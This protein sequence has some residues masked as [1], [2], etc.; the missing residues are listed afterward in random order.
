MQLRNFG[1][2]VELH[3]RN[4]YEPRTESEVIAILERCRDRK[5]RCVG[6]LHSWS[7]VLCGPDVMLNLRHL[8]SVDVDARQSVVRVGAGCQIKRLLTELEKQADQTLPSVGFITEQTVAGAISTGTHGSGRHSLSHYV[9][10]VRVAGYDVA[11]GRPRILDIDTG[12]DLR[13]ARCS[14]GCLGIILNVTMQCR[15]NYHVEEEFREYGDLNQVLDREDQFPLQQVY[16]V[17]WRWTYIAQHRRETM[18][19]KS[20]LERLYHWYRFLVFDVAMHLLILLAVRILKIAGLTRSLFRWLLPRFVIRGWCVTGS[21]SEQLV[22]EHERFRH[23]ELEL[24]VHRSQIGKAMQ[25]VRQTLEVASRGGDA[26][27][28]GLRDQLQAIGMFGAI[29][30]FAGSYTHHYPICVRRILPDDTLISMAS[31]TQIDGSRTSPVEDD[32]WYS[33]TLT[34]YQR[35]RHRL[36]FQQVCEFLTLAMARLFRARPHWGK[37]M[38]C[39]PKDLAKL[40]PRFREFQA[41]CARLDPDRAFGNAWTDQILASEQTTG[42]RSEGAGA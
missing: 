4:Y 21:A 11:T 27:T 31:P 25:F 7:D 3:P 13:A 37:L 30:D 26:V 10:S 33:I 38:C 32:A 28:I 6:R 36:P 29:E 20:R 19:P 39:E 35:S 15:E 18:Q 17:P 12:D 1:R 2:N 34:N 5:I 22:M 41:I 14:L 16:L 8:N 40:Y 9:I 24:F 42:E 23:V